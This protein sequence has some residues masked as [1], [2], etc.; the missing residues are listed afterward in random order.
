MP[1]KPSSCSC[2]SS[3]STRSATFSSTGKTA[4]T[5]VNR[6]QLQKNAREGRFYLGIL[7]EHLLAFDEGLCQQLRRMPMKMI[8]AFEQGIGAVYQN[9]YHDTISGEFAKMP[10]FQLQINSEENTRTLRDLSSN[11]M[12]Q[13]VVCPGIITST[14]KPMIKSCT[15]VIRCSNCQHEKTLGMKDG[16]GGTQMPRQCEQMK[17][18]GA[19]RQNC[20]LDSY[21]IVPDKSDL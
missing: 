10:K 2:T 21:R 7:L 4:K 15:L 8:P 5:N 9:H 1:T 3:K 17:N 6:E 12:G 16:F 13:L 11:V 19:G 14:S 20:P 18:P